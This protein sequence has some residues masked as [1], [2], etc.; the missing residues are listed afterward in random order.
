LGCSST[1]RS[2]IPVLV[3]RVSWEEPPPSD[4]GEISWG[5]SS[6]SPQTTDPKQLTAQLPF[7]ASRRQR[8]P[9]TPEGR[10][11]TGEVQED[12]KG[13]RD[14][15]K[16]KK[17]PHAGHSRRGPPRRPIMARTTPRSRWH[18]EH[19][20]PRAALAVGGPRR[21]PASLR[22]SSP[23]PSICSASAAHWW[24]GLPTLPSPRRKPSPYCLAGVNYGVWCVVLWP[25]LNG[26]SPP[27]FCRR[28]AGQLLVR[29]I[30]SCPTRSLVEDGV[31]AT[32]R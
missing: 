10:Q 5:V 17:S 4:Q 7:A 22:V 8:V 21:L 25:L 3:T 6:V 15:K 24:P 23:H 12:T 19:S 29:R 32:R 9:K 14:P 18:D 27:G 20:Q 2:K 13:K 11:K 1:G 30:D 16:Q 26:H 28:F 31:A